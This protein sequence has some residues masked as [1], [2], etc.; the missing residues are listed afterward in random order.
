MKS[1]NKLI[2]TLCMIILSSL[3]IESRTFAQNRLD[4]MPVI[5]TIV[6]SAGSGFLCKQ[7]QKSFLTFPVDPL[8]QLIYLTLWGMVEREVID[9]VIEDLKNQNIKHS[10]AMMKRMAWC[11]SW[12]G[13]LLAK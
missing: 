3:A 9:A 13:Y 8:I 2:I 11:A 5:G 6:L 10:P 7:A 12:L 1:K 4:V